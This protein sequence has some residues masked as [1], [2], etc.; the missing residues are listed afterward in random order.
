MEF[1]HPPAFFSDY[2]VIDKIFS[3][4]KEISN[5]INKST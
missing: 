1:I 5:D 4:R 2:I 3:M